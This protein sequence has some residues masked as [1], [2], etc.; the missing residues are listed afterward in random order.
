MARVRI[1]TALIKL[2]LAFGHAEI[3]RWSRNRAITIR[4]KNGTIF[5]PKYRDKVNLESGDIVQVGRKQVHW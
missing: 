4:K 2:K 5:H 3:R 1:E